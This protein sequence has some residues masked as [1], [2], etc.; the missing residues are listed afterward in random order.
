MLRTGVLFGDMARGIFLVTQQRGVL[1]GTFVMWK[2]T[3]RAAGA[4]CGGAPCV[5]RGSGIAPLALPQG[6]Q[7]GARNGKH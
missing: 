6:A 3:P 2:R 7:S 1:G 4:L 5:G